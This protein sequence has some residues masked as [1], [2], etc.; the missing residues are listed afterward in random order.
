MLCQQ[1]QKAQATVHIDEVKSF[2]GPGAPDNEVDEHHLCEAC[3]QE[4][5]LPHI[6]VQQ[7][8]MDEVWK[9]LQISALKAHKKQGRTSLTCPSCGTTLEQ[10]RRKG[11]VGCQDCYH[12]FSEYLE[13]LLERMHGAT[14]HEG[15]IPGVDV[16]AT[17][18]QRAVEEAETALQHAV[19]EEDFERAAQ[20]RDE[21]KRL[22]DEIRIE[23]ERGLA[24]QAPESTSASTS[25]AEAEPE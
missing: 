17:R 9:L 22:A 2:H 7:K 4:I 23:V 3:A 16:E 6:A 14:R 15:R 20:L 8:T 18:R 1:C 13:G 19:A 5:D 12:T 11:R 24:E 25:G 21:L 10:L